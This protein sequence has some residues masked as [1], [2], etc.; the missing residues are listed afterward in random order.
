MALELKFDGGRF[1]ASKGS[2]N[3]QE[4]LNDFHTAKIIR[5]V[6]YNISKNLRHDILFDALKNTQADVQLITNV[7]SRMERYFHSP[8]GESMRSIARDNIRIYISKLD[9]EHF[10]SSFKPYFNNHNHAKIIGTE[11]IVYIGSANYSNESA[12]NYETGVLIE[13]KEFIQRLYAEFFDQIRDDIDSLSYYD[14]N[15]SAF[16]VFLLSLYAK[17]DRHY[18]K[19]ITDVYTD[20]ERKKMS[21]ADTIFLDA[22]DL[23]VL[24]YDLD[25]LESVCRAADDTYDEKYEEYN[26]ELEEI[27]TRF[28]S[29]SIDWLKSLISEDGALYQL[30][31]YNP[32]SAVDEML[33]TEYAFDA[34]DEQLDHYV[35]KSMDSAAEVYYS[36]HADFEHV[37]DDF[38]AE[39]ERILSALNAAISFTRKWKASKINPDIDNT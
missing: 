8:R 24:Y 26:S 37:S 20:Y 30:V 16:Q 1:V 17:F 5:I 21:L 12:D 6:T 32:Q 33:Q 31:V 9:P 36:L 38:L 14:E 18:H 7:P 19:F 4:V 22:S 11:N 13:D 34:W 2:L 23:A 15:F 39:I 35:Q 3:F 10:P 28:H 27:K 29:L 25:E